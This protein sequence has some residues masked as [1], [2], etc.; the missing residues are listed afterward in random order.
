MKRFI[1]LASLLLAACTDESGSRKA[2]ESSGFS[3]IRFTGYSPFSCSD[4]DTFSTGFTAKNPA[5][6]A[7]KGTVCCGFLK[8]CTVRF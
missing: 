7:V 3:E 6:H 8:S 4:S 5:G 2:L 1:L